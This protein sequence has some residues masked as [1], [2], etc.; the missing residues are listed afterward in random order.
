MIGDGMGP[1][2]TSTYRYYKDHN[3]TDK[4]E[5]TVFDKTLTGMN[6]TYSKNSVITDSAAAGTALATR[7]K[8]ENGLIGMKASEKCEAKT[9]LEAAKEKGY[10]TA[11]AVTST[12]THETPAAFIAKGGHPRN[13]EAEIAKDFFKLTPKGKLKFDFLIGGGEIHF[14]QAYKDFNQT[15]KEHHLKIYREGYRLD[16]IK[17]YPFIAFTA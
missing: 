7:Y 3:T 2:Y 15:A 8:T 14:N 1:A 13:N 11:M 6:S 17:R 16:D 12:L 9:V 5:P 10:V 4:I